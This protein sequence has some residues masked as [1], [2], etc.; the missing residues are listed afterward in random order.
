MVPRFDVF[1]GKLQG[2]NVLW[3]GC[4]E[5]LDKA[6]EMMKEMAVGHPGKYFIF[7]VLDQHIIIEIDTTP[8]QRHV[9][10]T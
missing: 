10:H 5:N 8:S 6:I 7:S 1:S 3:M 9:E 4:A 2:N